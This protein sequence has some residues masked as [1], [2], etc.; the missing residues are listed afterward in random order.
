MVPR[1]HLVLTV[2]YAQRELAFQHHH[3]LF[4]EQMVV[5]LVGFLKPAAGSPSPRP[6]RAAAMPAEGLPAHGEALAVL[7][8]VPG[9]LVDVKGLVDAV[10]VAGGRWFGHGM[11]LVRRDTDAVILMGPGTIARTDAAHAQE[12]E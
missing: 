2:H 12:E 3:E 6:L 4:L 8:A 1:S 7:E 10:G 9:H 5:R 11:L